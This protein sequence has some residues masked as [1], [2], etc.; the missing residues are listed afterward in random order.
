MK[1]LRSAV[2][3]ILVG[4]TAMSLAGCS[5][6]IEA[7]S[8]KDFKN[9]IE[10]ALDL[11]DDDLAGLSTSDPVNIWYYEGKYFIDYY[12]YEDADDAEERFEDWYDDYEDMIEDK[13]FEGRHSGV[14][15]ENGGYGYIL[16]NGEADDDHFGEDTVYGGIYWA[17]DTFL[18][19]LAQSDKDKYVD[20][21]NALLAELGY[22]KPR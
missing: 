22:P 16:L 5:K 21:I 17:D 15:N 18:I 19:I 14:Y 3:L 6:K 9:A 10:E 7:L 2:A 13:D 8:K 4:S 1:A 20:G 11:D 12:Q